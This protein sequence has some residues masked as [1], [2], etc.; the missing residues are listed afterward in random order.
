MKSSV[1]VWGCIYILTTVAAGCILELRAES[2]DTQAL[3]KSREH[4]GDRLNPDYQPQ[5][6]N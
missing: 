3:L 6:V 2:A 4:C 5:T 1:G